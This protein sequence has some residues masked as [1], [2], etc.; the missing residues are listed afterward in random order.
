M[1]YYPFAAGI[2]CQVYSA[3]TLGFN[4]LLITLHVLGW[5]IYWM[6]SFLSITLCV[7]CSQLS[8]QEGL[9]NSYVTHAVMSDLGKCLS[10]LTFKGYD[11]MWFTRWVPMFWKNLLL[12]PSRQNVQAVGF[13]EMLVPE[14]QTTLC[15]TYQEESTFNIHYNKNLNSDIL[16]ISPFFISIQS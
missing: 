11:A 10:F 8:I 6:F 9:F 3:K 5:W 14:Y 1:I 13:Y 16:C 2:K 7:I 12:P 4:W 15:H